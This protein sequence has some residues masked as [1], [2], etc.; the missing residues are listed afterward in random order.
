[1]GDHTPRM[2][3]LLGGDRQAEI[4]LRCTETRTVQQLSISEGVFH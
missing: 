3:G 4:V 2:I 1:M